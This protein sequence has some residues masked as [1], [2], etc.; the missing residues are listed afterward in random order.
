VKTT[1]EA[2]VHRL[3]LLLDCVHFR[4]DFDKVMDSPEHLMALGRHN[5]REY[6]KSVTMMRLYPKTYF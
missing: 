2:L 4:T 1:V 3:E 6:E 5:L